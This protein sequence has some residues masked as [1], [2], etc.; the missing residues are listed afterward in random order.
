MT[1]YGEKGIYLFSKIKNN[2]QICKNEKTK[3]VAKGKKSTWLGIFKG[4]NFGTKL[5][6][7]YR[8]SMMDCIGIILS[9]AR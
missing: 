6:A 9:G 1:G 7:L 8:R 4:R 3:F 5:A 2:F